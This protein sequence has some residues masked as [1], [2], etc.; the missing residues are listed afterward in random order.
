MNNKNKLVKWTPKL[1]LC[2]ILHESSFIQIVPCSNQLLI[3][4]GL[5]VGGTEVIKPNI[6]MS[7]HLHC[8]K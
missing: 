6:L 2:D 1:I 7:A 8:F 4:Q 5:P 3:I